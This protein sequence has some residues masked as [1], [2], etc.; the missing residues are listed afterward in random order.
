[1]H[2]VV[3]WYKVLMIQVVGAHALFAVATMYT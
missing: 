3:K 1:M 2:V